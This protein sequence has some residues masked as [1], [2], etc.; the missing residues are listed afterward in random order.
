MGTLDEGSPQGK[1]HVAGFY[2]FDD[3]IFAKA[4]VAIA[5]LARVVVQFDL[6]VEVERGVGIVVGGQVEFFSDFTGDVHLDVHVKVET[7]RS[8]LP[9]GEDGIFEAL[10]V[11]AEG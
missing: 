1:A 10:V 11:S 4:F 7:T 9:F 8:A 3:F 2:F 6:V 5:Q